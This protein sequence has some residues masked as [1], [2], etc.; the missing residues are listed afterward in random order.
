[1]TAHT[2]W[3]V[4]AGRRIDLSYHD[5]VRVGQLVR[6]GRAGSV[7][8][9]AQFAL[10]AFGVNAIDYLL[11]PVSRHRL[12]GTIRRVL[13]YLRN[14]ASEIGPNE[15]EA[16]NT[17][18]W[19]RTERLMARDRDRIVFV[20]PGDVRWFEVYGNYVRLAVGGRYL[21][22]RSTLQS[23]SARLDADAF[24]RISRSVL[25]NLRYVQS[26]RH[27]ADG[28]FELTIVGGTVLRSSSRYRREVRAVLDR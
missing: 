22:V 9:H 27:R 17:T 12:A 4:A 26:V 23:L 13:R 2:P 5:R 25:V 1:M 11:K 10:E 8:A 20:E 21:L 16:P 28:R 6:H 24:V 15:E 14:D 19:S 3:P 18:R 7:T